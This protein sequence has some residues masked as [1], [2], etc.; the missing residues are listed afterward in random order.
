[1]PVTTQ[2][3]QDQL[4]DLSRTKDYIVEMYYDTRKWNQFNSTRIWIEEEFPPVVRSNIPRASGVYA[5]VLKPDIFNFDVI[6]GLLYVGKATELYSRIGSYI[7]EI[8]KSLL[9]S[10]RPNI[11]KMIN[12][13]NGHLKY[14]YTVTSTVNEAEQLEDEMIEAFV[15]YFNRSYNAET[16]QAWRAF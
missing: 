6:A 7:S 10:T 9:V 11:W 15:P 1:M 16:S 3:V 4:D 5:F 13:W 12:K 8:N 14:Y 2:Q